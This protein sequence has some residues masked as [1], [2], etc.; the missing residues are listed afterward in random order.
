M[1]ERDLT[2]AY[3]SKLTEQQ[4]R[5][6]V[7]FYADF[8]SG[9]VRIWS[10]LGNLSWDGYTWV[11]LGDLIKVDPITETKDSRVEEIGVEVSGFSSDFFDPVQIDDFYG[12]TGT[13]WM[14]LIDESTGGVIDDPYVIFSGTLDYDEERFDG[15]TS[16]IKVMSTNRMADL[17]RPR[18][19]RYTHEHQQE[20]HP[21]DMGLEF[22]ASLQD[23]QINWGKPSNN[24]GSGGIRRK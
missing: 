23:L 3:K 7:F 11:G 19:Y 9:A 24:T 17:L 12:R 16:T 2:A 5:V 21:G 1:S 8:P 14:G 20:L 15:K 22:V 10:G 18:E 6:V 13:I 4:I